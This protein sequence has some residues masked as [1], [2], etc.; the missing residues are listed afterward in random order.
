MRNLPIVITVLFVCLMAFRL[1]AQLYAGFNAGPALFRTGDVQFRLYPKNQDWIAFNFGGG[2][3][4][5]A[6][7]LLAKKE[8]CLLQ[9]KSSGYHF[10]GGFRNGLTKD[11]HK[12][13]LFWGA[14]LV[15]SRVGE[16][17]TRDSCDGGG[18]PGEV[19]ENR[20][21]VLSGALTGGYTWNLLHKKTI[22]QK[23][24]VD[25]GM[26]IGFPVWKDITF[27]G[28]RQYISGIGL[29]GLPI[30]SVH[31]ELVAVARWEL[32]HNRFGYKK[33]RTVKH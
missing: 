33:P 9:W 28:S 11:H 14:D 18:M 22:Y 17:A 32:W 1:Q 27:L 10:R 13:H 24:L 2:G 29:G 3:T 25:F 6:P 30:R 23:F 26:Q 21:N 15:Y 31:F 20:G 19:I 12:S 8:N 7:F 4:F 5:K 16:F